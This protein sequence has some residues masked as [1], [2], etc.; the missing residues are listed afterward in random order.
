MTVASRYRPA[1]LSDLLFGARAWRGPEDS[2]D[3]I[4]TRCVTLDPE[5]V[6]DLRRFMTEAL[7]VDVQVRARGGDLEPSREKE[8]DLD[9][10]RAST[11]YDRRQI[12]ISPAFSV[13]P[14]LHLLLWADRPPRVSWSSH[15]F[16][17]GSIVA[18]QVLDHLLANGTP[19]ID[20]RYQER[21]LWPLLELGALAAGLWAVLS[22]IRTFPALAVFTAITAVAICALVDRER[23]LRRPR[24]EQGRQGV[25][26]REVSRQEAQLNR[27][28]RKREIV[29]GVVAAV[30]G[31]A[32]A[33]LL[34]GLLH[35]Y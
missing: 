25:R 29:I 20:W 21:L 4:N 23:R 35:L 14:S 24:I 13:Q 32:V 34:Q 16:P 5:D 1:V 12:N 30:V 9:W 15:D 6:F 8:I 27:Y 10:L 26:I 22:T 28:N 2:S 33:A 11:P 18:T 7:G 19:R 17:T 31:A 3:Q